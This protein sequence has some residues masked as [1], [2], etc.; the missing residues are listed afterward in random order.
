M[1]KNPENSDS[2]DP[3]QKWLSTAEAAQACGITNRTL[4]RIVDQGLLPAYRMGRVIRVKVADVEAFIEAQRIQ[5]GELSHLYP[6]APSGRH[7]LTEDE[8]R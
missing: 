2:A 6:D 1:T 7:G 5:P 3:S 4:Y 8:S